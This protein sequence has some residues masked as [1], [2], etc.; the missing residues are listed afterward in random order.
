MYD[1]SFL[2]ALERYKKELVEYAKK[3]NMMP[4]KMPDDVFNIL[5]FVEKNKIGPFYDAELGV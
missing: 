3:N 1:D 4:E 5:D 2:S